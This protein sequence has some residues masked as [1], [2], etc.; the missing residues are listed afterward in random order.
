MDGSPAKDPD[1]APDHEIK[2]AAA[3]GF[4]RLFCPLASRSYERWNPKSISG[5]NKRMSFGYAACGCKTY[6]KTQLDLLE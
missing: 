1:D 3:D 6:K 4:V 2:R 5:T